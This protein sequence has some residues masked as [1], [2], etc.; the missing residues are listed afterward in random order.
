LGGSLREIK[1]SAAALQKNK[2]K[3][4]IKI[5]H[6]KTVNNKIKKSYIQL[7]VLPIL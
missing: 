1:I 7:V 2:K 5:L 4:I 6:A 3:N